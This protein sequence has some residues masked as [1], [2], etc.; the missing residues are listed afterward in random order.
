MQDRKALWGDEHFE[1]AGP[2]RSAA[3]EPPALQARQHLVNTRR[4]DCE[5]PLQVGLG[6]WVPVNLG[7]GM[8]ERQILPL[9]FGVPDPYW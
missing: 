9:S 2:S 8:N 5:E 4:G 6:R 3:K 7:I 1:T